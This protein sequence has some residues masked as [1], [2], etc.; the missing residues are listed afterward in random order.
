MRLKRLI[1]TLF[2]ALTIGMPA[3]SAG[4]YIWE[5]ATNQVLFND[6]LS[7]LKT[8]QTELVG[9]PVYFRTQ[10]LIIELQAAFKT[11]PYA[12]ISQV[13]NF[14]NELEAIYPPVLSHPAVSKQNEDHYD[15]IRRALTRLRDYPMHVVTLD[16]D[17]VPYPAAQK[18]AFHAANKQ[19]LQQKRAELFQFLHSPR[20]TGNELQVAKLYSS[21]YILRTKEA[22]IGIDICYGEGLYVADGREELENMLDAIFITHAHGDH[23]DLTLIGN[24]LKMGKPAIGPS[25]MNDRY[26]KSAEGKKYFWSESQLE[27]VSV[28]HDVSV[29]A[30][31]GA[32]GEEPCLLYLIQIGDWRIVHVGDNSHHENEKPF[33][34][35]YQ[36]ADVVMCPVFQGIVD[37]VSSTKIA[38]N[39]T[40]VEQI[41]MN[42]HENEWH[43]TIDGR[44]AYWY[45]YGF[46]GALNNQSFN[47]CSTAILENGEHVI[48]SK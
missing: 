27:S 8:M 43:H 4:A 38:P 39:P 33:Y 37:L 47:Y 16:N 48:L 28:C 7:Y 29:Q 15:K 2:T 5:A 36:I 12:W 3:R 14:C 46:G 9:E 22:C 21:G 17:T 30:A 18:E 19:W 42:L 11:Q 6:M 32:Q 44:I 41:Y 25:T 34:P 40:N 26:F 23:F 10:Q 24:M 45:L 1:L 35:Q 13:H 31:M 20:P